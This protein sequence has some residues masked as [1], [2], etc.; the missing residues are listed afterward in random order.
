[1]GM[2]YYPILIFVFIVAIVVYFFA[3]RYEQI[4]YRNYVKRIRRLLLRYDLDS[5]HLRVHEL[6]TFQS[7]N[8]F[9]RKEGI[10]GLL[11]SL[12]ELEKNLKKE[13]YAIVKE[14]DLAIINI[15]IHRLHGFL[16]EEHHKVLKKINRQ[17][18]MPVNNTRSI[19][20]R[21]FLK[22]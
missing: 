3:H 1:M 4:T 20:Q 13:D 12:A 21:V 15:S 6:A 11:D 8:I 9:A 16:Q 17:I 18:G 19:S 10:R 2:N 5:S 7:R 22:G 14:Q